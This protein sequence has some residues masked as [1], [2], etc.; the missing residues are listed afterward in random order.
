MSYSQDPGL[1]VV[2]AHGK[3]EPFIM[4]STDFCLY[5]DVS[6][7]VILQLGRIVHALRNDMYLLIFGYAGSLLLLCGLSLVAVCG[8]SLLRFLLLWSTGSRARGLSSCSSL[9]PEFGLSSCGAW[10]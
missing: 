10:T 9:A 7:R 4:V 8:L 1:F 6:I 3:Q 2:Y 5:L